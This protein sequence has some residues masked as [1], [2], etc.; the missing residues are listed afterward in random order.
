MTNPNNVLTIG[1]V[2][3]Q[4]GV[5]TSAI[6]YYES[7][8]LLPVGPRVSGQR[9]YPPDTVR[10][11]GTLRFAQRAG[12]SVS[13]IK[14]LFHGFGSEIPPAARW[15]ALA[16]QKLAELDALIADTERMREALRKGMKCGCLKIEDCSIE[17]DSTGCCLPGPAAAPVPMMLR[18]RTA[19]SP[20][21]S[22][23]KASGG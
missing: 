7:V 17:S 4:A 5:R 3:A 19:V 23:R 14:T 12:F 16:A 21:E 11:I 13:E 6:R 20:T 1:E 9:R 10:L 15:Q 18:R 22:S 2:A 8:G